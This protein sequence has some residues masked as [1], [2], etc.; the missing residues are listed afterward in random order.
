MR[1]VEL[2]E[3]LDGSLSVW[4][5]GQCIATQAT[6]STLR[7]CAPAPVAATARVGGGFAAGVDGGDSVFRDAGLVGRGLP[8]VPLVHNLRRTPCF[9]CA[10]EGSH[11]ELMQR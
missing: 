8:R 4:H 6:P 5:Q 3:H 9:E 1:R 2:R 11:Q 7:G 10:F